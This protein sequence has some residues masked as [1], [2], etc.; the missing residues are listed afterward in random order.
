MTVIYQQEI[1]A[2][3]LN[4]EPRRI[5]VISPMHLWATWRHKR[6]VELFQT[7]PGTRVFNPAVYF[8]RPNGRRAWS[9]II[10]TAGL[11]VVL[12]PKN[13]TL[14]CGQV[15]D[16]VRAYEHGAVLLWIAW[17]RDGPMFC[18]LDDDWR[19]IRLPNGWG[20]L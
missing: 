7:I 11:A 2:T 8:A 1:L 13:G 9:S 19:I 4:I 18:L 3:I 12:T 15:A 10:E 14:G 20:C 5:A 6:T 16:L 17:L